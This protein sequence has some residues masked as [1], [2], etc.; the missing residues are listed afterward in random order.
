MCRFGGR[1]EGKRI[2][3]GEGNKS[4]STHVYPG[5]NSST[6][7]SL[8]LGI[9]SQTEVLDR[10]TGNGIPVK[11][12]RWNSKEVVF[13]WT[14]SLCFPTVKE[15]VV[16]FILRWKQKGRKT[17]VLSAPGCLSLFGG[18]LWQN[19]GLCFSSCELGE[20]VGVVYTQYL[21]SEYTE[22]FY[23]GIECLR[24]R[25]T[26]P[27]ERAKTPKCDCSLCFS[28]WLAYEDL[29]S[30]RCIMHCAGWLPCGREHR[31]S[32]CMRHF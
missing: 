6:C 27:P 15:E 29:S 8:L 28:I 14:N 11:K 25:G 19:N 10:I 3:I 18:A 24:A 26:P 22:V 30:S 1:A 17:A 16:G 13:P 20:A 12:I 32:L 5:S 31:T 7:Q 21:Y 4:T 2:N 23:L 9:E